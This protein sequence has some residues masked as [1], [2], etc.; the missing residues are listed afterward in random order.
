MSRPLVIYHGNCPDGFTAAW[1][2]ARAL[3]DVELFAGKYGEEPPYALARSRP[4]W[5][6]DF[7]YPREQLEHLYRAAG[8]GDWAEP[9]GCSPLWVLDHH[10]TAQAALEGLPYCVFDMNRSG[11]GLTWDHFHPGQPRPWVVDYVEDRDLWRFKLP[12][13]EELSLFIRSAPHEL[14]AWDGMAQMDLSAAVGMAEGCKRYLDHYV[15][16]AMRQAY[17]LTLNWSHPDEWDDYKAQRFTRAVCVNVSYTGVSDVLN[18]A[19]EAYPEAEMALGWH[20]GADRHLN[21]SLRS[22]PGYDCSAFARAHGGGGHARASGFR[23]SLDR[24]RAQEIAGFAPA[25]EGIRA[26][27]LRTFAERERSKP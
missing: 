5:I 13:S 7:S 27:Y 8:E 18:A 25:I 17:E 26:E 10:K 20:L 3:G 23:L 4:V 15:A 22:R 14:G 2:A 19:L 24:A 1:V 6:V 21:C 9:I 12:N 16:D 11:A